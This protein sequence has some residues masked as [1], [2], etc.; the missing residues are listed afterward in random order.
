MADTYSIGD[1][2]L[3][4]RTVLAT[5]VIYKEL[6]CEFDYTRL[7]RVWAIIPVQGN[8]SRIH[9]GKIP[10]SPLTASVIEASTA[11]SQDAGFSKFRSVANP[12]L[13]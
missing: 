13:R 8:G 6:I 12:P 5:A 4:M 10:M 3:K 2:P 7:A 9:D 11:Y 1:P